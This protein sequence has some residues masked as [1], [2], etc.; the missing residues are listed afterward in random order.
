MTETKQKWI[1]TDK[2]GRKTGKIWRKRGMLAIFCFFTPPPQ[3]AY[4]LKKASVVDTC[5][6]SS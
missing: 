2:N 6:T 5:L 3:N 1:K 4:E